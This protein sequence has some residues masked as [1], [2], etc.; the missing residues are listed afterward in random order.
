[1][2]EKKMTIVLLGTLAVIV[3]LIYWGLQDSAPVTD[4]PNAIV[5][6]HGE[7]CPHCKVV[8]DFLEAND[9]AEKVS[10]EKKEV[11]GDKLNAIEMNRRAKACGIKPEGMGVP[12][13]YGG[14]GT[15]YV[16]E[17]DVINFFKTKAGISTEAP[18][19]TQK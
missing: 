16:G 2:F 19:E 3:G 14:D 7:G 11:W 15:C 6:Y 1:M 18:A 9:I 5:Y 17:P 4:D 12:F 8:N 13:V 10:F